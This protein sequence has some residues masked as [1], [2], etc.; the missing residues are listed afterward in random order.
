MANLNFS[1]VTIGGRLTS[2]PELRSTAKGTLCT[3]FRVAV[4]KRQLDG[5]AKTNFIPC[6]AWGSVADF[7]TKYFRKGS[8]ILVV[9]EWD[10]NEWTDKDGNKRIQS[11]IVVSRVE[12]VDSKD[13]APAETSPA[14]VA[15]KPAPK[16]EEVDLEQENLPF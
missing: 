16:Y 8:S 6:V 14:P 2:S 9:G 4:N 1:N 11:E 15:A 7:V 10:N 12:F 5:Q 13:E 3:N